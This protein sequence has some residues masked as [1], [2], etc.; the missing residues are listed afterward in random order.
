MARPKTFW[1][2][3]LFNPA[4]FL[5]AVQQEVTRAHAGWALDT[6]QLS[7]EVTDYDRA[8]QVKAHAPEGVYVH[9][10]QLE[11]AAWDRKESS[12]RESKPKVLFSDLPLLFVTATTK[13]TYGQANPHKSSGSLGADLGPFGGFSYTLHSHSL[14]KVKRRPLVYNCPF[15]GL[16]E[17]VRSRFFV[18]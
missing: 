8:D 12:L 5:T 9:G 2:P 1:F 10:L 6:V 16:G 15:F 18:C 14:I 7:T 13:S 11:C 3:G 4:G 17:V